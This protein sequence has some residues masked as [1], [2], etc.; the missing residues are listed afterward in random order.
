MYSDPCPR[1]ESEPVAV[2]AVGVEDDPEI[3]EDESDA[4]PVPV[5]EVTEEE[6]ENDEEEWGKGGAAKGVGVTSLSVDIYSTFE[7]S[8]RDFVG[9]G[10][11]HRKDTYGGMGRY[12][13][14]RRR[15]RRGGGEAG[16]LAAR[17]WIDV[18]ISG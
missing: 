8:K 6:E 12:P 10:C 15:R 7:R 9:N 16:W 3:K 2:K 17:I 14:E 11:S 18:L 4:L 1:P 5:S 13:R